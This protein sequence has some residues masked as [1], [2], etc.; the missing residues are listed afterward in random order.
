M[1]PTQPATPLVAEQQQQLAVARVRVREQGRQ[2]PQAESI[3]LSEPAQ[4][5]E[6]GRVERPG[7]Q[8]L[9]PRLVTLRVRLH[10]VSARLGVPRR[11]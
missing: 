8:Q 2:Q 5:S 10:P 7:Q 9:Q 1:Q 3:P 4:V 11:S 6:Q